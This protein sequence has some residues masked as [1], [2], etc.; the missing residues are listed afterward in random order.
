[1]TTIVTT[2][3]LNLLKAAALC[4]SQDAARYY[5]NGV[6]VR[7]KENVFTITA[8]DGHRLI[9]FKPP[10]IGKLDGDMPL[11]FNVII[12]LDIIK[13][14]KV[15]KKAPEGDLII[16]PDGTCAIKY[17]GRSTVFQ[18]V[19]GTFP[20]WKRVVPAKVD[21]T[22]GQYNAQYLADFAKINDMFRDD[23]AKCLIIGHNGAGPALVHLPIG[24]DNVAV[25]MP[26]R[27]GTGEVPTSAPDW[28]VYP[29]AKAEAA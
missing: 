11:P 22:V 14:L 12:P 7:V 28:A 5:L 13:A 17:Q 16:Q 21:G 19:D 25:I 10:A 23:K 27:T 24:I 2:F 4:A 15:T 9:S 8:T 18:P 20:D 6:E 3:D 29:S 26:V 1:M